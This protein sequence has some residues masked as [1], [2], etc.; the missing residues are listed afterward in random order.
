MFLKSFAAVAGASLLL[1]SAQAGQAHAWERLGSRTVADNTETDVVSG[2][3]QGKFKQVKLCVQSR[4]VHFKDVDV[5]FGNGGHQDVKIRSL[6]PP[7]QCTRAIDLKGERR[8]INRVVMR[9][10]T[11]RKMGRQAVVTVMAR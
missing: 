1:I 2:F 3:G 4:A 5:L 11:L 10:E 7:G 6:I 9:Y 8:N